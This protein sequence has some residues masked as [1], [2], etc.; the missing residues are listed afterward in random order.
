MANLS[1]HVCQ[2]KSIS[3]CTVETLCLNSYNSSACNQIHKIPCS[4]C[5][6]LRDGS[7]SLLHLL[8]HLQIFS[9]TSLERFQYLTCHLQ[10]F[11]SIMTQCIHLT[12]CNFLHLQ[13]AFGYGTLFRSFK[14][15][16]L[17]PNNIQLLDHFLRQGDI[18]C[19]LCSLLFPFFPFA[20]HF[21]R[22]FLL[23]R[24]CLSLLLLNHGLFAF[25]FTCDSF[26]FFFLVSF[27]LCLF[28]TFQS[29][30]L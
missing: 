27:G 20:F 17:S 15:F 16:N 2:R 9:C 4:P 12:P 25:C 8:F 26:L 13:P 28:F 6:I 30:F 10:Y 24:H 5:H 1:K 11:F 21:L 29:L 23:L 3:A 7:I 22:L 14:E 18:F 19:F